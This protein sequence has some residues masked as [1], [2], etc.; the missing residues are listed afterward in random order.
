VLSVLFPFVF[1]MF[2]FFALLAVHNTSRFLL[3]SCSC[4]VFV[5]REQRG[6]ER[7]KEERNE[8]QRE[9][10]DGLRPTA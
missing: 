2:T 5:R 10:D 6:K 1:R 9:G 7:G 8:I 4:G 3:S